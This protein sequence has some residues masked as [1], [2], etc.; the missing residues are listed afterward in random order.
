MPAGINEAFE[1]TF[2]LIF[3]EC[4]VKL[5]ELEDYLSKWHYPLIKKNPLSLERM[6]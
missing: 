4:N 3:G 5:E 2:K 6:F 1:T